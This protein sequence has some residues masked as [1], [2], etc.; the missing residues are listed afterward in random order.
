[1]AT[2]SALLDAQVARAPDAEALVFVPL[3]GDVERFTWRA[4]ADRAAA[5]AAG[6]AAAGLG[7]G[8]RVAL[9]LGNSPDFLALVFAVARLG[10]TFVPTNLRYAPDELAY[11]LGHARA[12]CLCAAPDELTRHAAALDGLPALRLRV[13]VAPPGA[14]PPAGAVSF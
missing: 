1:M 9:H 8:D 6:L 13:A 3:R 7:P 4:L 11:A 2:L 10:A 12:A 5:L 14:D